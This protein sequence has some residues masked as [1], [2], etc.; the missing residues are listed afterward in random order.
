MKIHV[1]NQQIKENINKNK[2]LSIIPIQ[3][4]LKIAVAHFW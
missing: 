4:I 1:P 2:Y 3:Y